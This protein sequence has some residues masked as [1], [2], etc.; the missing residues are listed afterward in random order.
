[1]NSEISS[2]VLKF[3]Q[4]KKSKTTRN[5][6]IPDSLWADIRKAHKNYPDVN[7]KKLLELN[8]D[9]W[10][11]F[12]LNFHPSPPSP[13]L[14]LSSHLNMK[15][16]PPEPTAIGGVKNGSIQIMINNIQITIFG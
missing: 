11:K 4:W 8:I 7:L 9:S 5:Q 15:A 12:V 14:K 13:F 3:E 10:K 6:K 1:M 2:L 16:A